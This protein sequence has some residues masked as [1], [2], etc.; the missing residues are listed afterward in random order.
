[1]HY[2]TA[3]QNRGTTPATKQADPR[4]V[5]N[6]GGGYTFVTSE[7][8]A[9]ERFLILGTDQP[10]YYASAKDL[11]EKGTA[12]LTE[13]IRKDGQNVV[14]TIVDISTAGRAPKQDAGIYALALCAGLGDLDTRRAAL[15]AL[16]KVCR[17]GSTLL[18]FV[19]YIGQARG[20]GRALRNALADWYNEKDVGQLAYQVTKYRDRNKWTHRDVFRK[21]HPGVPSTDT[22]RRALYDF[23]MD[24][25]NEE[26]IAGVDSLQIVSAFLESR[27]DP[28][29]AR[30]IELAGILSHEMVPTEWKKEPAVWDALLARMPLTAMIRNLAAMTVAGV[31]TPNSVGAKHVAERLGNAEAIRAARV[32]PI[33]LLIA[34]SVYG[35][36]RGERGGN[37]WIPTREIID[38]LDAAFYLAFPNVVPAGKRT[39]VGL[40]VSGSMDSS[41]AGIGRLTARDVCVA[42]SMIQVATE[43]DVEVVAFS[44]TLMKLP[45]AKG[46]RLADVIRFTQG[47]PFN[48]TDCSLPMAY[49]LRERKNIDTFVVYT[50]NET[51]SGIHP[52]QALERYR[53]E[54]VPDAKLVVAATAPTR[55][56]IADPSDGGMLDVVGFD[57]NVPALIADFSRGRSADL[58]TAGEME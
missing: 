18:Q 53:R 51:N 8:T 24:R 19:A 43:P 11:T 13:M 1:M 3:L 30:R 45:F 21:A 56:T 47:L 12:L 41:Q 46:Q 44:T 57:S 26:A 38:S 35:S 54:L 52:H 37:T 58:Q 20:W 50:D 7:Q 23:V 5:P 27:K 17:T 34:A 55:F 4:Q 29:P 22:A 32:H 36:G 2:S 33:A 39:L 28:S 6:S 10:T 25:P 16:P 49:A 14:R 42:M 40:D 31:L 15:A 48:S 9:L